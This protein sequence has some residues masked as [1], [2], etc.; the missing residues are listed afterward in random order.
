ML[1][2]KTEKTRAYKKKKK[3]MNLDKSS[4]SRLIS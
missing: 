2:S 3:Q 1:K 4:Q